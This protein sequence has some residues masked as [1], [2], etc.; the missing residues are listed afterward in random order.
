MATKHRKEESP[1]LLARLTEM[2]AALG[3][4]DLQ[5][6]EVDDL[7]P[8]NKALLREMS[9]QAAAGGI[10]DARKVRLL[11]DEQLDH[12]FNKIS[13]FD[14]GTCCEDGNASRK[15]EAR[16]GDT[17][18]LARP[19]GITLDVAFQVGFFAPIEGRSPISWERTHIVLAWNGF[20]PPTSE[21]EVSHL[22][23]YPF[24]LNPEHLLWETHRSNHAREICR[25]TRA[26][27]CP[28]CAHCIFLC[29]HRPQCVPCTVVFPS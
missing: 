10:Y 5:G 2:R 11:S 3:N 1:S 8:R 27:T 6:L 20:F 13:P 14:N 24:C 26:I 21:H 7:H 16:A 29:P 28:N 19:R 12:L 9:F 25:S 18:V 22:C 4:Q 15:Q 17:V 23:H